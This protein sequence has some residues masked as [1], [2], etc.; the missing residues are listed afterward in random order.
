M[1]RYRRIRNT[2]KIL[3]Q[4]V[5]VLWAIEKDLH[6]ITS[7]TKISSEPK[8]FDVTVETE[9]SRF[10]KLM[11]TDELISLIHKSGDTELITLKLF[12]N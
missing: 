9:N 8:R 12:T 7:N 5:H 2:I 11:S 3:K 6:V 4:L 1:N 10:N